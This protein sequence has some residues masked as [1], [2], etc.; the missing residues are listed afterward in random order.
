M[1]LSLLALAVAG[2]LSA[3]TAVLAQAGSWTIKAGAHAV[4][5]KSDNGRLANAFDVTI[6]RNWRPSFSAEYFITDH[7]G[8]EVLAALPFEHRVR[9]NGVEA[10][11]LKHLPP[12]VSLQY[13]F[14]PRGQV[15]PYLG[16][17]VNHTRFF[18]IRETGPIAGTDLKLA[19]SWGW[20]VHAG[21]D[22]EVSDRWLAG[23]DLR[24][25]DIDTKAR[26]DG[27]SIGTVN[28]DPTVYGVYI[29]YRF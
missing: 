7:F 27:A 29:G 15:N 12:T 16:F 11:E 22:F 20:A 24:R 8:I 25:I 14:A 1:R 9:L 2:C 23:V 17:G 4:D 10:A 3:P 5:P 21:L 13:H 6:N 18:S 19:S 28:V 26:L